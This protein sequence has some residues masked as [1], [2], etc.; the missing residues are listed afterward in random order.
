MS[1]T[2]ISQDGPKGIFTWRQKLTVITMH[3]MTTIQPALCKKYRY[4]FF[5]LLDTAQ[6]TVKLVKTH[7]YVFYQHVGDR[8][9][10]Y[11][12]HDAGKLSIAV[13]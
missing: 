1:K 8:A 3:C 5:H 10:E 2:D 4:Y 11:R 9:V 7:I 13:S 6:T 12:K